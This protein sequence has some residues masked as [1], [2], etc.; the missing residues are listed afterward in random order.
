MHDPGRSK[1]CKLYMPPARIS[2][3]N[4][5]WYITDEAGTAWPQNQK[6]DAKA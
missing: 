5:R 1:S 4:Q 3:A 2:S 6:L